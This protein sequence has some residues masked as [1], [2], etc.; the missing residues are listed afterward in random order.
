MTDDAPTF[1][2]LLTFVNAQA[3]EQYELYKRASEAL[4]PVFKQ[5]R[6]SVEARA[7]AVQCLQKYIKGQQ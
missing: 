4:G 6:M 1:E 5:E 7:F 2:S 3:D